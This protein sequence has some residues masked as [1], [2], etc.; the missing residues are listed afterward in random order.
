MSAPAGKERFEHPTSNI[1]PE[2]VQFDV[3]LFDCS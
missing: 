3:R 2:A 1:E